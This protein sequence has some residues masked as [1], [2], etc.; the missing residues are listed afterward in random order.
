MSVRK[1]PRG[2][3]H[4]QWDAAK[5]KF[6]VVDSKSVVNVDAS[7]LRIYSI[8]PSDTTKISALAL[9]VNIKNED[10]LDYLL[11]DY[12][13]INVINLGL[14]SMRDVARGAWSNSVLK[15]E[16]KTRN[17][18]SFVTIQS[19]SEREKLPFGYRYRD[20]IY[21]RVH[22]SPTN[23]N[24]SE[25]IESKSHREDTLWIIDSYAIQKNCATGEVIPEWKYKYKYNM[26]GNL[27]ENTGYTKLGDY[28]LTDSITYDYL[29]REMTYIHVLSNGD[30]VQENTKNEFTYDGNNVQFNS[31]FK[32]DGTAWVQTA[33]TVRT[34]DVKAVTTYIYTE[35][36]IANGTWTDYLRSTYQ[37]DGQKRVIYNT[38]EYIE[39]TTHEWVGYS[40][41]Y[42][43]YKGDLVKEEVDYAYNLGGSRRKYT[44]GSNDQIV[45]IEV[46]NCYGDAE[47]AL[48]LYVPV[49]KFEYAYPASDTLDYMR[50]WTTDDH[51]VYQR[52]DSLAN[53]YDKNGDLKEMYYES[54]GINKRDRYKF[55]YDAVTGISESNPDIAIYPNPAKNNLFI[56]TPWKDFMVSIYD[57]KGSLMASYSNPQG[58]VDVSSLADGLYFV[59]I[60]SGVKRF[61]S[62]IVV[63]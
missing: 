30:S 19:S 20:S 44:Y 42:S 49:S 33:R 8:G 12:D 15:A 10:I 14:G 3:I 27:I 32:W 38:S 43:Y 57:F 59:Q 39:P 31:Q 52:M 2:Y 35:Q 7:N 1:F 22:C 17:G 63:R 58:P 46:F 55:V 26:R 11:S 40:S 41:R 45:Q 28:V 48:E 23:D 54:L 47:C 50:S 56:Q 53:V 21:T 18:N 24:I 16:D 61:S 37:Y 51:G 13:V 6:V 5:E 34:M 62:K 36:K 9:D 60:S 25:I 4:S 29:G